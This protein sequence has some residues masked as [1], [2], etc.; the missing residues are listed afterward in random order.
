MP[1]RFANL[2]QDFQRHAGRS[3]RL[4]AQAAGLDPG[5]YS[6]LLSGE[7]LPASREQVLALADA[8]DLGSAEADRLTAAAGFLPPSIAT[9]GID[10]PALTALLAALTRPSLSLPARQALRRTI[11]ELAGYWHDPLDG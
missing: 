1:S 4:V 11:A 7:R 6:R 5:R 9:V 8:L 10:D 2:L 3:Q